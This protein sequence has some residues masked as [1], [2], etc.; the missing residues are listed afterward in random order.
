M[1]LS[2]GLSLRRLYVDAITRKSRAKQKATQVSSSNVPG[3]GPSES[4]AN[5]VRLVDEVMFIAE[6]EIEDIQE[7]MAEFQDEIL[8]PRSSLRSLHQ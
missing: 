6:M 1:L 4:Q 2:L 8:S 3:K 5:K 7:E